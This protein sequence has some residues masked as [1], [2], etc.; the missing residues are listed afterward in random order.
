[1]GLKYELIGRRRPA[2]PKRTGTYLGADSW[3]LK[4]YFRIF[5]Q[6]YRKPAE[7]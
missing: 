3:S 6:K 2:L 4:I 7:D 5:E 1:V